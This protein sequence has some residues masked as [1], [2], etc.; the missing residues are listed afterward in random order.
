MVLSVTPSGLLGEQRDAATG[1]D[2]LRAR[3]YDSSLGRFISKDE[4]PGYLNDPYSQ[5][6]YQY[7]HANPVRYTDPSGYFTLGD[8]M[9]A[10]TLAGQL[11]TFSGI[12]FGVGYIAGAAANGASGEEILGMFGEWGA[13]FASGVSGGFLTD[14][15]EFTTGQKIE[16][17][18]A[19][20]YNAGNVTGIGV[21]FL[22][23]MKA[24]TW[25]K[26]AIGPLKWVS[27]VQTGLDVYDAAK[28]TNNLY[29]SYQD[30]G[31]F[32]REDAWNLL[33][34]VPFVGSLLGVKKFFAANKA[35]KEGTE[36][37]DN[38]LKNGAENVGTQIRN[39]FV[40]GTEILTTEGIKNIEDIKVGDWVIAD[41]PTT[42]GEIEAR[43]VTDT[44]VRETTALVDLY[45]D[46]EVISTTGEHPFWTPDK[47]WV[48]A[49]DLQVG[50]LLQTE[51]GRVI[52]VDRVEKREGQFEVYNFKVDGFHSYFVSGLGVLVHNATYDDDDIWAELDRLNNPLPKVSPQ[53][54]AISRGHAFNDHIGD[55]DFDTP[56]DFA[57][58]IDNIINNPSNVKNLERGRTAYW[59]NQSGTVIIIDPGDIDGGTAFRPDRGKAYFDNL[60]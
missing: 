59:D 40:A 37:V 55:F 30:N 4:F 35:I 27:T 28:A 8:A 50:S 53:A 13:G 36:G 31:K 33:A 42:P 32:E 12:G 47:G 23:G 24:A 10:V 16:P 11:A 43:Q 5:H 19:M 48:E 2:Y 20:L 22:T 6:D 26:T 46:G 17:K 1:L 9:A 7:A 57:R 45:V 49:K 21:S 58:H 52:D 60:E 39:C 15:Y 29:Q 14:V 54:Q 56:D 34:Y 51:D 38:V 18:H 41:D 3:Y 44:F 25:A